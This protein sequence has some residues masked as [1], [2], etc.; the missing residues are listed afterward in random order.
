[1]VANI[2]KLYG[3]FEIPFLGIDGQYIYFVKRR[4]WNRCVLII[5]IHSVVHFFFN[6]KKVHRIIQFNQKAWLKPY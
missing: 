4:F 3:I 2:G 6:T 5:R 1:M